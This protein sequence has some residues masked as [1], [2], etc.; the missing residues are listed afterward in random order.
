MVFYM[1][2]IQVIMPDRQNTIEE[3]CR[4]LWAANFDDTQEY[5]EYYF[6]NRWH[7]SI[8]V[9]SDNVSMLNL[10][11]YRVKLNRKELLTYYIVGVCTLAEY[12]KRGY[13]DAVLR[14]ALQYMYNAGMPFAYLM[15]A[16][17]NIYKPYGFQG[18]YPARAWD[19]SLEM[20][21]RETFKSVEGMKNIGCVQCILYEALTDNQ[22]DSLSIYAQNI[23]S[24]NFSCYV[25]HD[26]HY[27]KELYK[28]MRACNGGI[29]T[30][31]DMEQA[32]CTG[33]IVYLCE[34]GSRAEI[35]ESVFED[36]IQHEVIRYLAE[37]NIT[38]ISLYE[39]AFWN[40]TSAKK[41]KNYL[42]ARIIDLKAFVQCLPPGQEMWFDITDRIISTNSGKWHIITGDGGT[43]SLCASDNGTGHEKY[44]KCT[45]EE[46][47]HKSLANM[48]Y[49]MNELV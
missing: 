35:A 20:L 11:P 31:W 23:L 26:R 46:F 43:C 37:L 49:Y 28:E 9:I 18:I 29:A 38:E 6:N 10:N 2:N 14:C 33:Y 36:G 34:N 32:C 8:T 4:M 21:K 22:K 1:Y 12:R 45:I 16:S 5:I 41:Q 24:K 17:E 40:L 13:M 19:G 39:T 30:F 7:E 27:F 42:M 15:P 47:G 44:I 48:A 3:V 25:V